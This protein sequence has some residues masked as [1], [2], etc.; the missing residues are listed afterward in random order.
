MKKQINLLLSGW[1]FY[2][3][4]VNAQTNIPI[5]SDPAATPPVQPPPPTPQNVSPPIN[6]VMLKSELDTMDSRKRTTPK[7]PQTIYPDSTRQLIHKGD[8]ET[9][10]V[11]K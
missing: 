3:V 4:Y 2:S 10:P 6:K 5:N 9:V 7:T 8:T 11:R 1:F